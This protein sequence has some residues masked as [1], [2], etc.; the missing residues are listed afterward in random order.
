[1][2]QFLTVLII[3]YFFDDIL[4]TFNKLL[5]V[6][7]YI[8]KLEGMLELYCVIPGNSLSEM[9]TL[10]YPLPLCGSFFVVPPAEFQYN[11]IHFSSK[12]LVFEISHV[13]G[14]TNDSLSI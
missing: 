13:L 1:M 9:S 5:H 12:C 14:I 7:N 8:Y 3:W 2:Y 11:L 4:T 10:L 6:N